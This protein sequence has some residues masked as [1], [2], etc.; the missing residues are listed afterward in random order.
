MSDH[1]IDIS[2][3]LYYNLY[4][5][6][7]RRL[8]PLRSGA[9]PVLALLSACAQPEA[10]G[11]EPV[12][13][14]ANQYERQAVAVDAVEVQPQAPASRLNNQKRVPLPLLDP[15]TA[16]HELAAKS[17]RLLKCSGYLVD[18]MGVVFAGH[19]LKDAQGNQIPGH[20]TPV[21]AGDR[22]VNTIED[23]SVNR[24]ADMAFGAFA[25]HTA[26]EIAGR[27]SEQL[28]GIENM[29][30]ISFVQLGGYPYANGRSQQ[31][32]DLQPG[33][34]NS[35]DAFR[36]PEFKATDKKVFYTATDKNVDALS[37]SPGTSGA[38]ALS[39]LGVVGVFVGW[40]E[41][42]PSDPESVAFVEDNQQY[43]YGEVLCYFSVELDLSQNEQFTYSG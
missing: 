34:L 21:Y 10:M 17:V 43:Q 13:A 27:F 28:V 1:I 14:V 3:Y 15:E 35:A 9:L 41:L 37:C 20:G 36:F 12:P 39:D 31:F 23:I 42:K 2:L 33:K 24:P 26:E 6:K 7:G 29:P 8:G 19:C 32:L 40:R 22:Y 30:N 11:T 38:V 18:D 16:R 25:G 5:E 4:M